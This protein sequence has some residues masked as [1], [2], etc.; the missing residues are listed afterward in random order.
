MANFLV[1]TLGIAACAYFIT[2]KYWRYKK[3]NTSILI[4]G[5]YNYL[6]RFL[7]IIQIISNRGWQTKTHC[8]FLD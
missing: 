1:L 5:I 2:V 6:F 4:I 3:K 8:L 7:Q